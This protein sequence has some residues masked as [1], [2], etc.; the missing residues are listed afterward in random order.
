[1]S[2]KSSDRYIEKTFFSLL[3]LSLLLHTAVFIVIIFLPQ[4]KKVAKEQP[5]MVDLQT[6]V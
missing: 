1:M 6:Y 4:E 5:V 3:A 2:Y